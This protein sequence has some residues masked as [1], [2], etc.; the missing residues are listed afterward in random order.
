MT[1]PSAGMNVTMVRIF[2]EMTFIWRSFQ[3]PHHNQHSSE[4]NPA[5]ICSDITGL[6][7][8][9]SSAA[10]THHSANAVDCSVNHHNVDELPQKLSGSLDYGMDN[11]GI[12]NLVHVVLVQDDRIQRMGLVREDSRQF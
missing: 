4:E 5:G 1:A 3:K 10:S 9:Q 6:H 2:D 7:A 8:P 12:I 11:D